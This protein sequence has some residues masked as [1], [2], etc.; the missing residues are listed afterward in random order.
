MDEQLTIRTIKN[1]GYNSFA[2]IA[3]YLLRIGASI[4][5]AQN[6]T[7][8]DYGVIGFAMVIIGFLASFNEL[9][10]DDAAV[11]RSEIDQKSL[12]TGFVLKSILGSALF[13]LC[14]ILAPISKHFFDHPDI[15]LVINLL[16]LN[17]L[18]NSFTFLP[19]VILTRGLE[20]NKL[21]ISAII[22]AAIRSVVV[23]VLVLNNY[24]YWS[25]VWGEIA[26]TIINAL[27][28]NWFCHV[29][30]KFKFD[31]AVAFELLA[32]GSKIFVSGALIFIVLN[33]DNFIIGSVGGARNLGFYAIAFTWGTI[34]C[35]VLEDTVHSV[36]FPTFARIQ[37]N[38]AGLKQAY[39][40]VLEYVS[41]F[42][43][44]VNLN[45]IGNSREILFF[46]LGRGTDKWIP[47]ITAF[48]ILCVYA[49]IKIILV[50]VGN[51]VMSLGKP[52]ILIKAN[53][54][55]A[56]IEIGLLYPAVKYGGINAVAVLV[57]IAYASQ[58]IIYV[59]F[60]NNECG[61][62]LMEIIDIIKIPILSGI[63]IAIIGIIIGRQIEFS[64]KGM[65]IKL[66]YY[67]IAY[68][69]LYGM[70]TKW[71]MFHEVRNIAGLIVE[72]EKVF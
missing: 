11:Q 47:A 43:I 8:S 56:M 17:F 1:I 40:K 54:L 32:F 5:V 36:L 20:Y 66:L 29:R 35:T 64:V 16:A 50:P 24:K 49:I 55:A 44:L 46:I 45:L 59:S 62:R 38:I 39:L 22:S 68:L 53:F 13:V 63:T 27:T 30:P 52:E 26:A 58:Y 70:L 42:G 72:K 33:A 61:I 57:T 28:L 67:T 2:K 14:T 10:I 9:G 34:A 31:K 23:I 12:Y 25:I 60:L 3:T 71:R 21:S 41:M 65:M 69:A 51:V 15:G 4:I 37:K 18:I 19:N 7:A 48:E 6:L